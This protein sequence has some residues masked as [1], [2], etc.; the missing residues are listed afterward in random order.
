MCVCGTTNNEGSKANF[1]KNTGV[2]FLNDSQNPPTR[3][4]HEREN[5]EATNEKDR[6]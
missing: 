1:S 3:C 4:E 5:N 2:I 6:R